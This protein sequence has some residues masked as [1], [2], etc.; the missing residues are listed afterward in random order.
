MSATESKKKPSTKSAVATG[1][2]KEKKHVKIAVP[3]QPKETS[4]GSKADSKGPSASDVPSAKVKKVKVRNPARPGRL[5]VKSIFI[6][7]KRGL[8]NQHENTALLRIDG[9]TTKS[10]ADFYLGKRAAYVYKA[11]NK[12]TVPNRKGLYTKTRVIWGKITRPHGNSGVVRA[13]FRKNLPPSA[14]GSRV[15]ILLYPSRI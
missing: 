13:K 14:M 3:K 5:Y 6:G 2:K 4:K 9:V 10:E 1:E 15:R 12:T 7:F 11:K 8:R